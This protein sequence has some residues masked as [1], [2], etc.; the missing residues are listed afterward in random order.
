MQDLWQA[1]YQILSIIS[2]KEF[3]ELNVNTGRNDK[4]CEICGII[5]KYCHCFL[6]YTNF[7]H[8]LLEQ[9]CFCC[10]KNYE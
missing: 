4:K 2:L 1:H 8:D 10:N 6:E 9:K 5:Y 7:K 3:I